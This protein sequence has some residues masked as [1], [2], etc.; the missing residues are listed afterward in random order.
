MMEAMEACM[1]GV[2]FGSGFGWT[3]IENHARQICWN[4]AVVE[5]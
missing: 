3:P 5:D 4:H 2:P 1:V